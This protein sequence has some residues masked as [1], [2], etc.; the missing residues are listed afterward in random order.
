MA[1]VELER[2]E[3]VAI[4]RINRPEV[5]NAVNA[6]VTQAMASLL[7]E[8]EADP[9]IWVAIVTGTGELAF[10]AGADLK[11]MADRNADPAMRSTQARQMRVSGGGFAGITE[12]QFSKPLIAAVNGYALGGGFE[13]CLACDLV[14]AEEHAVFGLP[15]VKRGIFAGG[16]GLVRLPSRVPLPI[17]ME[18]TLT[19]EPITAQRAL[20]LGLIN[21]VVPSGTGVN[22][23]LR[24]AERICA[25]APLSV[26]LSKRVLRDSVR[27]GETHAMDN[28]SELLDA[29]YSS[30]DMAEGPRAFAE[31]RPPNWT[32]R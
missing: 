11:A 9:T 23:A 20:S 28:A 5:R 32:G 7:A 4:A 31:K 22:A 3:H 18:I 2:R 8:V 21:E 6:E 17:A 26:R 10:C 16:G 15:E 29:L 19:G 25:N 12:S 30:A 14:I 1:V 27:Y 24:L 13:I